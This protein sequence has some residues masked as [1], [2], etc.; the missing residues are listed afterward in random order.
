[1]TED[2]DDVLK[3]HLRVC[4]ERYDD[5]DRRMADFARR[6]G[7]LE[8]GI[9]FVLVSVITILAQMLTHIGVH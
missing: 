9:F 8:Y 7:R 6:L 5:L 3:Y 4:S 1:M 2:G